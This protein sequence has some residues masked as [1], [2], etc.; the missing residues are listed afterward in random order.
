MSQIE[1][2]LAEGKEKEARQFEC[3]AHF[4]PPAYW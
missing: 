4:A 1:A 2:L 3:S